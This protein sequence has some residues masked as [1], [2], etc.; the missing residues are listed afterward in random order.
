[1]TART[2]AAPRPLADRTLL[3]ENVLGERPDRLGRP[4]LGAVEFRQALVSSLIHSG[5]FREVTAQ[6]DGEWR[7]RASI[8][9]Q[10]TRGLYTN[11]EE[12]MIRY[13]ITD[14]KG[15]QKIHSETVF[16]T[17]EMGTGQIY[18]GDKRV[19]ALIE[20]TARNNIAEFI[21]R[22]RL[23]LSKNPTLEN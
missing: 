15:G 17:G 22:L 12:L 18:F 23:G 9:S 8:I 16:T 10:E 1:M 21:K 6:G 5:L 20:N 11:I 2:E 13:E 7:L 19:R 4:S 14:R 3:V